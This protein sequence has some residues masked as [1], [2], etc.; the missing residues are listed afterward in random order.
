MKRRRRAGIWLPPDP[1]NTLLGQGAI[2]NPAQNVIKAIN[3]PLSNQQ[4]TTTT[5]PSIPMVGDFNEDVIA[6]LGGAGGNTLND[7]T[8]GYSLQRIVG[9]I[10]LGVEQDNVT[11][12]AA[13]TW[14]FEAGFMVRRVD[15]GGVPTTLDVDTMSYEAWRD[16]WIWRRSWVL[17][18]YG[19]TPG[20]PSLNGYLWPG[21]NSDTGSALDGP[22]VDAK[23]HRTVKAEERLFFDLSAIALDGTDDVTESVAFAFLDLR[24]FGRVFQSAG[25]KRNATR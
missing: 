8:F 6:G 15:D 11:D 12:N 9:K 3:I 21:T 13:S 24:F 1:N 7:M 19:A 18:N 14:L 4:G 10:F 16:P 17:H 5:V 20:V 23:T 22:H 2:S 25:N